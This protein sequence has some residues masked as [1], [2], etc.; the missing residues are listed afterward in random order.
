MSA[1]PALLSAIP[2]FSLFDEQER[3]TLGELLESQSYSSGTVIYETGEPGDCLYI[4]RSG[5]VA[6]SVEESTGETL[7]L[8][9]HTAGGVFGEMSLLDG[10]P[11]THTAVATEPTEVLLLDR[12]GLQD[13][14]SSHPHSAIDLLTI[15]GQ[16]LR[17]SEEMQRN[18]VARNANAEEAENLTFAQR[19]ADRVAAFGG[20]WTFIVIFGVVI[21]TWMTVNS[22]A[23][24]RHSFDP[25]PY[26]L[27]NLVLSTVAAFQ[28][29]IIMMSQNRQAQKDRIKNELDYAVNLKAELEVAHLHQK[30]D[31]IYEKIQQRWALSEKERRE[32]EKLKNPND[33]Y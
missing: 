14:I 10:G 6:V 4:V 2:V 18:R 29:P 25:Y 7:L 32:G 19:V 20:S 28:A 8:D 30:I 15:V 21:A 31:R 33:Y 12:Q 17:K 16:R 5:R 1:N 27:L 22:A 24:L 13:L 3:F 26:I 11:R 9:E 23:L